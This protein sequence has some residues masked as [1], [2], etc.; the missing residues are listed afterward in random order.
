ML[1]CCC[2]SSFS[3]F[4]F[5]HI[6]TTSFS[7]VASLP[8]AIVFYASPLKN[9]NSE[10]KRKVVPKRLSKQYSRYQLVCINGKYLCRSA[11]HAECFCGATFI[12]TAF[13][14][15]KTT[16]M[17]AYTHNH[18]HTLLHVHKHMHERKRAI[19]SIAQG[20]S[21]SCIQFLTYECIL[22]L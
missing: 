14:D 17:H 6:P 2:S 8:H 4:Y 1:F 18:T 22:S 16:H 11:E 3:S 20:R 21:V 15:T 13:R 19:E 10:T 12:T 5:Q 9:L 7:D